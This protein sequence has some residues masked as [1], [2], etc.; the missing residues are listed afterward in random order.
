MLLQ[1]DAVEAVLLEV[2]ISFTIYVSPYHFVSSARGCDFAYV[3]NRRREMST[4][5]IL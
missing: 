4:R 5:L 3:E 1:C 2:F